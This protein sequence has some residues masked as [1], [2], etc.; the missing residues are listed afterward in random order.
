MKVGAFIEVLYHWLTQRWATMFVSK[1]S[2]MNFI[3]FGLNDIYSFEGR[4]WSFMY[5]PNETIT[6]P[7]ATATT[8][9]EHTTASPIYRLINIYDLQYSQF[10]ASTKMKQTNLLINT[11]GDIF[12]LPFTTMISLFNNQT[13][14]ST[15]GYTL[16][17]LGWFTPVTLDTDTLPIPDSFVH[18]LYDFVMAYILPVYAQAGEQRENVEYQRAIAKLRELTKAD[19]I[20]FNKITF[21]IK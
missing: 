14:T 9:Y 11:S 13:T 19:D 10:L 2:I 5:K 12:F 21:N 17:Y 1:E 4:G 18:A 3:N 8:Y 6:I 20:Q 7:G 15:G 16:A